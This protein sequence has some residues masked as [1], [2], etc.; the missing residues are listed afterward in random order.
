METKTFKQTVWR[1]KWKNLRKSFQIEN[2][3]L[4]FGTCQNTHAKKHSSVNSSAVQSIALHDEYFHYIHIFAI[5]H[6][7]CHETIHL[8]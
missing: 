3:K 2:V 8:L 5:L 4:I 1:T 7:N 6:T